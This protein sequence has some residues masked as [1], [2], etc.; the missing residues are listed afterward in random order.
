VTEPNGPT[1]HICPPEDTPTV[2]RIL[3]IPGYRTLPVDRHPE[4][5]EAIRTAAAREGDVRRAGRIAEHAVNLLDDADLLR[6]TPAPHAADLAAARYRVL[7][8]GYLPFEC[9]AGDARRIADQHGGQIQQ[10]IVTAHPDGS[11]TLG[12]WRPKVD[13]PPN[14][15]GLTPEQRLQSDL[16][17]ATA[18]SPPRS[19]PTPTNWR[20][21]MADL[22]DHIIHTAADAYQHAEDTASDDTDLHWHGIHAA[23]RTAAAWA[24]RA[25]A[26]GLTWDPPGNSPMDDP[27]AYLR[28]R[29]DEYEASS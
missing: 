21:T 20:P 16:D 25:A 22:P 28:R 12:P 11:L 13:Q 19:S 14:P 17:Q 6:A 26:D 4:A 18:G 10:S 15:L 3:G 24:L 23:A 1:A 8:P 27:D 5:V 29:A 7:I 2:A 9:T